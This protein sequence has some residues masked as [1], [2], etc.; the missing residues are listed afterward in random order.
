LGLLLLLL[1]LDA[2]EGADVIGEYDLL[3]NLEMVIC[4]VLD[5]I[6]V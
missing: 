4:N 5:V 3:W 6:E 2:V 1:I